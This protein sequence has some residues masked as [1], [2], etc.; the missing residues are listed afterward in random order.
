MHSFR[1]PGFAGHSAMHDPLEVDD[2]GR[3]AR[4]LPDPVD[5]PL[6]PWPPG[7]LVCQV[8]AKERIAGEEKPLDP[9][10]GKIFGAIDL[11]EVAGGGS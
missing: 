6:P 8:A 1:G 11:D 7:Q 4:E 5:Q 3:A 2:E 9:V 10:Y